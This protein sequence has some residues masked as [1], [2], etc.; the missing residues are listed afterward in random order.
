VKFAD[1]NLINK[2]FAGTPHTAR[3]IDAET[4]HLHL[5]PRTTATQ[6]IVLFLRTVLSK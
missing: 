6:Q 5:P 3:I 4:M 2:L 1:P